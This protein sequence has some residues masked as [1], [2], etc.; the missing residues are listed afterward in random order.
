MVV[1]ALRGSGLDPAY[2][3][4]GEL[5][6]TGSNAGWGEGRVDRRR[7]R[8]V[9]PLAA[10]AL[11]PQIAV[12]TNVELDHH[13]TYGSR[14]ELE[15]TLPR[16]HGPRRRPRRGLG[17]PRAAR[18]CA[19]RGRSRYDAPEPVLHPGGSRF[20]WRGID[21]RAVGAGRPQR[22]QRR[23]RADGRRARR[24]RARAGRGARSTT[25]RARGGGSSCW[26]EA[27]RASRCTTTTRTIRPRSPRRSRPPGRSAHAARRRVS[28]APL[29]AHARARGGSSG[30]ALAAADADRRARRLSG[31]RAAEDFPGVDG[32]LVAA[33]AADAAGGRTVAW[34]PGFDEAR[35]FLA[36]DAARGATS[37]S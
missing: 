9:R 17:S 30:T 24:G 5:R 11:D 19:R 16:V 4:G 23:R 32:R 31:A 13:S 28:A 14:L 27:P 20:E 2:V 6:S 15:Q 33:A 25:S 22:G 18:R 34:L 12:L 21:G 8:R 26:A 35:R 37:A 29:L 7:G 36:L 3:L 1:H 10:R